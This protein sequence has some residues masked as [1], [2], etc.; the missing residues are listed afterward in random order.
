MML[1]RPNGLTSSGA[2]LVSCSSAR[3]LV[4]TCTDFSARHMKKVFA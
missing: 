4:Q 3:H 2:V 1:D